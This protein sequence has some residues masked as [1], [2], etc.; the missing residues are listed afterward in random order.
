[1]VVGRGPL[2]PFIRSR[3]SFQRQI[4][5]PVSMAL[6]GLLLVFALGFWLYL[7]QIELA[8]TLQTTSQVRIAWDRLQQENTQHLHWFA[9][10]SA[11][12]PQL[13]EAMQRGDSDT[14]LTLTRQ[15]FAELREQ[16]GISHWYFIRPDRHTLLRVHAPQNSGDLIKRRTLADA[17]ASGRPVSGL[18]LGPL[19]TYTLR[20]VLPWYDGDQLLGY[21]EMGLEVEWFAREIE[22]ILQVD[23]ITAVDKAYTS[24]SAFA[25]GK[26]ALGFTGYWNEHPRIAILDQGRKRL[27]AQLATRWNANPGGLPDTVFAVDDAARS[28]SASLLP[29]PDHERRAVASLAILRD[30]TAERGEGLR[31]L[32]FALLVAGGLAMLL[33]LALSRRTRAIEHDLQTAHE[34]LEANEQRYQDIFSTSSDWWFWETDADQRFSFL[35]DNL[36]S[37]LGIDARQIIGKSRRD[38]MLASDAHEQAR[39]DAHFAD[40]D[41]H[42]AFHR[43]EYQARLPDGRIV[44][45]A[46]S[47]VPVFDPAGNFQGYRG[48]ASDI[49]IRH[50]REASEIDAREGAETKFAVARILQETARPLSERFDEVLAVLFQMRGMS[51]KQHGRIL[52]ATAEQ[53]VRHCA[54]QDD[55]G[56]YLC[57][58]AATTGKLIVS[59]NCAADSGHSTDNAAHGHYL[60]P[61]LL[62]SECLGVLCLH[63]L[64]N[65]SRSPIRLDTLQQIG[66]LLA[67]AIA[68]E[69]ALAAERD[70]LAQA[71]AASRAKSE[72]LANMS[73]ELR[74]PMNGVIGMC[75]LLLDTPLTAEQ[76]EYA[77]IVQQSAGSLLG[78]INDIL[79]FSKIEAGKLQVDCVEFRLP[80]IL[81]QTCDLLAVLAAEKQLAFHCQLSPAIPEQ[82]TGDPAR[83]RQVLN[84]LIGNAIK[85]TSSGQVDLE[86]T[87]DAAGRIRFT[88]RDTGIGMTAQQIEHLFQPFSQGDNSTTR[89]FGGTGLGLS[90]SKRLVEMMG[91]EIGVDSREGS[92]S[93]FW[94]TL[95]LAAAGQPEA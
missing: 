57:E 79:D 88:V 55:A 44:W 29:L 21:I 61:L 95:P 93:A 10:E 94:F 30:V 65:P 59:D 18:E 23:I 68:N 51:G 54:W 38:I 82:V 16:F 33:G 32:L 72:F 34:S 56:N 43:F 64:P 84:N 74:T 28:W 6:L 8:R 35:S 11:A 3:F 76:R 36:S 91:G 77:E 69:R 63:T 7:G 67:L 86:V 73:H 4:L 78:V 5:L 62:G 12:D 71:A 40:L 48:A 90:I 20:H 27:P 2:M 66:G 15:R 46:V 41:A 17:A 31:K 58:R 50:E 25:A 53:A 42:Q 85:F 81:R 22:K 19:G 26:L 83:L 60:V 24:E 13:R 49:T 70:A 37:L 89:R 75:E 45:L 9:R 92:G 14:L 87:P 52:L 80:F 1:M 47:G 39:I